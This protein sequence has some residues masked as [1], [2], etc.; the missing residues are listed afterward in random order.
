VTR[1]EVRGWLAGYERAWRSQGTDALADLFSADATYLLSP[2]E[3]P[4]AGLA[5]IGAMWDREREGPDEQFTM[6]SEILAIDGDTAVA[7]I[8]V[9]YM[10]P[11]PR[12]YRDLWIIRFDGAGRCV[13]FEEWPFFPGQER[14]APARS[15]I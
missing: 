15:A 8:E 14:V 12:E 6:S 10:G 4:V 7:R 1:D 3:E 9:R 13:H 11:P 2:Y 5:A